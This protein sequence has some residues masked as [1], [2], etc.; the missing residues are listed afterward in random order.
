MERF[1]AL[2]FERPGRISHTIFQ[3]AN[4]GSNEHELLSKD[5]ALW[6]GLA[7]PYLVQL[8]HL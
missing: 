8:A 6:P 4:C 2:N 3:A 1:E 5:A 7:S